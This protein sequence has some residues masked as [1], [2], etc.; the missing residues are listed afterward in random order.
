MA[1]PQVSL[2]GLDNATFSRVMSRLR[3]RS[4]AKIPQPARS[5]LLRAHRRRHQQSDERFNA[6]CRNDRRPDRRILAFAFAVRLRRIL[7]AR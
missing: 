4:H 3:P 2:A 7:A 5:G 1:A 6:T